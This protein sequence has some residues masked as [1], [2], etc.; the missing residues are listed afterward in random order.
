MILQSP[1]PTYRR[2]LTSLLARPLSC[3]ASEV[4]LEADHVVP[5][6]RGGTDDIG[7]IQPLCGVCNR[8]KFTSVVDYRPSTKALI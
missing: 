8:R 7:N 2:V 3:G 6:T 4:V 1:R 5:L